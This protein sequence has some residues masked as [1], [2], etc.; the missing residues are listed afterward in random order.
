MTSFSPP[1][2]LSLFGSQSALFRRYESYYDRIS[3]ETGEPVPEPISEFPEALV[4]LFERMNDR[5]RRSLVLNANFKDGSSGPAIKIGIYNGG[6]GSDQ[7]TKEHYFPVTPEVVQE[8]QRSGVLSGIP[9]LGYTD[10]NELRLNENAVTRILAE[11]GK[12][13][14][15]LLKQS[16]AH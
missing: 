11:I 10:N 6:Y 3:E 13:G 7:L 9:Y 8:L 15:S 12:Y 4:Y 14:A 1:V 16:T 5:T 2:A